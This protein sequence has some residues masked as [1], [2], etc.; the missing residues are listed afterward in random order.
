MQKSPKKWQKAAPRRTLPHSARKKAHAGRNP[1]APHSSHAMPPAPSVQ[2]A[3]RTP[4]APDGI[5]RTTRPRAT[6]RGRT[7]RYLLSTMGMGVSSFSS[8]FLSH[9]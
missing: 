7:S 1:R 4:P 3:S 2:A 5:P 8:R 9:T 6:A